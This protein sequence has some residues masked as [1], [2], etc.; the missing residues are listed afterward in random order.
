M[1]KK[2]KLRKKFNVT[3]WYLMPMLKRQRK[4][5][6]NKVPIMRQLA[7]FLDKRKYSTKSIT[8]KIT[9]TKRR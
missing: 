3:F 6:H 7:F 4:T 1:F 2:E 9:K 8:P 5:I